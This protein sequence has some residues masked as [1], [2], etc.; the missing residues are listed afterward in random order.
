MGGIIEPGP[1]VRNI[2]VNLET[3]IVANTSF[4]RATC[5]RGR[6]NK[7]ICHADVIDTTDVPISWTIPAEANKLARS[8]VI[9]SGVHVAISWRETSGH[10]ARALVL[11]AIPEEVE[12]CRATAAVSK[13]IAEVPKGHHA[14]RTDQ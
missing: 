3:R 9:A 2:I 5:I 4:R 1:K 11:V 7:V 14:N 8:V 6:R 10:F 12:A 13:Q